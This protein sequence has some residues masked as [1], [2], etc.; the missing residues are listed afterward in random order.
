MLETGRII[1]CFLLWV[2]TRPLVSYFMLERGS[3]LFILGDDEES[4]WG[5]RHLSIF[6]L[7]FQNLFKIG[8]KME[9]LKGI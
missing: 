7:N 1:H 3:F 8:Y 4:Q 9:F 2:L 5:G 6:V